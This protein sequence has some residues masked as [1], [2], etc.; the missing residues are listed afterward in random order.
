M[1]IKAMAG[2]NSAI[3]YVFLFIVMLP[4]SSSHAVTA[5]PRP[6]PMP[7]IKGCSDNQKEY[8]KT[9]WR[10]AHEYSWRADRMLQ[11]IKK[12]NEKERRYL[13]DLDYEREV[14][15]STSPKTFFGPWNR[16]RFQNIEDA[17][18]KAVR[19][20]ENRGNVVKG[21]K[22][23]R[24]GQ[25]IAK[26]RNEHTDVCT[27]INGGPG[28]Y[29]AIVGRIVTCPAFWSDAFDSD[30]SL[31]Y[32]LDNSAE[33]LVH[34]IFHWLSVD[35]KYITDLHGGRKR[36][37]AGNI[38]LLAN[39]HRSWAIRNNDSY[40]YFI[41]NIGRAK[42]T[43]SA[44]WVSK[45]D[46][47]SGT[48]AFFVDQSWESFINR[49]RDLGTA[50]QYLNSVRTYVK[51]GKRFYAGVWRVG[52]RNG[53]LYRD[54][55]WPG[56]VNR[57]RELRDTQNLINIEIYKVGESYRYIGVWRMKAPNDSGHG[58]LQQFDNWSGLVDAWRSFG[59]S[60]HLRDIETYVSNG[61]R[62]YV[63]VSLPSGGNGALFW[64]KDRSEFLSQMGKLQ[65]NQFLLDYEQYL[66]GGGTWNY[67]GIW[68]QVKNRES[69]LS[70]DRDLEFLIP[71]WEEHSSDNML[72][73]VNYFGPLPTRIP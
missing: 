17:V 20:F 62:K 11:F 22:T 3:I 21:I 61:K 50:G 65:G 55:S 7:K 48:G 5:D 14:N 29:H 24:C 15:E 32:R 16:E 73:D 59:N 19:R 38:S 63:A 34:E 26:N 1:S 10:R 42:P 57:Y 69:G 36:Y 45:S 44:L 47:N 72:L 58:G 53:A 33:T 28:A 12:Q 37:G 56:L 49:W 9:A 51:D 25:P 8:L 54:M 40:S 64:Y 27:K 23:L 30:K 67:L 46:P 6:T 41:R 39:E 2:I 68:K 66:D 4:V 52:R 18:Q 43:F 70:L 13:W 35:G 31:E 60:A 71:R